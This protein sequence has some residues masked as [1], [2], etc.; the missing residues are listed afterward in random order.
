MTIRGRTF[1]EIWVSVVL[2][3]LSPVCFHP[4]SYEV[5]QSKRVL[6]DLIPWRRKD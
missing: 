2:L 4:E 5:R 1:T 3:I 6:S